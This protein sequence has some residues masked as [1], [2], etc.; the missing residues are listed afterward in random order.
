MQVSTQT[1]E[2]P[3]TAASSSKQPSSEPIQPA[4][5]TKENGTG[6]L[7]V[8]FIDVVQGDSIFIQASSGKTI[9]IDGGMPE[10]GSKVVNYIKKRGIKKIDILVTT[11]P[12]SDHIEGLPAVIKNFEIGRVY[13]PKV[14]HTI[15]T[16]ENMLIA[17]KNKGLKINTAKAGISL[18]KMFFLKDIENKKNILYN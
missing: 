7:T 3:D 18:Q 8:S 16:F 14:T 17:V 2:S 6:K 9:L 10:I 5:P 11:H 1:H 12:H 15:K 4:S 13:M